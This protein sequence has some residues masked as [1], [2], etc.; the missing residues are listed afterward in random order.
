MVSY[1]N[2]EEFKAMV[3]TPAEGLIDAF[4]SVTCHLTHRAAAI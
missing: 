2:E 3:I 1:E 4:G